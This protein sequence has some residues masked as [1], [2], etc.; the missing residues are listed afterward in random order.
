MRKQKSKAKKTSKEKLTG[1]VKKAYSVQSFLK[2]PCKTRSGRVYSRKQKYSSKENI[3]GSLA[4]N[5][6]K[7]FLRKG[8]KSTSIKYKC[9]CTNC[10]SKTKLHRSKS[11][12]SMYRQRNRKGM[13]VLLKNQTCNGTKLR[14]QQF[15]PHVKSK[16]R[17]KSSVS[18]HRRKANG[19]RRRHPLE[20]SIPI[21]KTGIK[22][23]GGNRKKR[24]KNKRKRRTRSKQNLLKYVLKNQVSRGSIVPE[25]SQK[26]SDNAITNLSCPICN[27]LHNAV[28]EVTSAYNFKNTGNWMSK[29]N[30]KES[31][32]YSQQL[33]NIASLIANRKTELTPTGSAGPSGEHSDPTQRACWQHSVPECHRL[34]SFSPPKRSRVKFIKSSPNR[35]SESSHFINSVLFPSA[36]PSKRKKCH[37]N[38]N[39]GNRGGS[40]SAR[41][42]HSSQSSAKFLRSDVSGT[43]AANSSRKSDRRN[44][45]DTL[46][47]HFASFVNGPIPS[48]HAPTYIAMVKTA[49]RDLKPFNLTSME[50]ISK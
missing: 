25:A 15:H 1:N 42:Q 48:G 23:P 14:S 50:A 39:N 33:L 11:Y 9:E 24:K 3:L 29:E 38:N 13:D 44:V 26:S 45:E 28:M 41:S 12:R 17:S 8:R 31:R 35:K 37:R 20:E 19:R 21:P 2:Q 36:G 10:K 18:K 43:Y 27:N 46:I 47:K 7:R 6:E 4:T 40:R 49:I 34:L 32:N 16:K 22:T 30:E 5:K